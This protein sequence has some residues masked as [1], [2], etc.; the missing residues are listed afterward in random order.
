MFLKSIE[1]IGFKSFANKT[2][3]ELKPGMTAIV[4]PNGCG[5][6]NIS[7]AVRWVLGEQKAKA[8]RGSNMQDV[9]FNGA[10]NAKPMGMAEVSLTLGECSKLLKTDYDEICI[11][12]RV[13][14]SNESGYF[15]NRKACRLKDIQRLFMDTGIGTD[16]YS[17]L[18]QGKIDQILSVRPDDRRSVF[19]EASGITKYKA[20]KKETLRKLDQTENNLIRLDDVIKEVKRQ[21]ISLQRQ[22]GKARRYKELS[23]ELKKLDLF[24]SNKQIIKYEDHL[25]FLDQSL[26]NLKNNIESLKSSIHEEEN[27][28]EHSRNS[29]S[30]VEDDISNNLELLSQTKSQLDQAKQIIIL[31]KDRIN[32][33]NQLSERNNHEANSAQKKLEKHKKDLVELEKTS[34]EIKTSLVNSKKDLDDALNEQK[35]FEQE[36]L[37]NQ[38]N[39]GIMRTQSIESESKT[40]KLQNE[41]ILMD[42]NDREC[43]LRR[44]R[45]NAEK[46]ELKKNICKF[47]ERFNL[48]TN[49]LKSLVNEISIRNKKV[50]K[51]TN[52]KKALDR[53][54]RSRELME[55]LNK[56]MKNEITSDNI[57]NQIEDLFEIKQDEKNQINV[58]IS[59]LEKIKRQHANQ[60]GEIQ[61][62]QSEKN[63]LIKRLDTVSFESN[64]LEK[65]NI[66]K[67]DTR[68]RITEEIQNEKKFQS[69]NQISIKSSNA[70]LLEIEQRRSEVFEYTTEK[71]LKYSENI[72]NANQFNARRDPLISRINELEEIIKERITGIEKYKLRSTKLNEEINNANKKIKP[73]SSSIDSINEKLNIKREER[74]NHLHKVSNAENDL[75]DRRN[76]LQKLIENKSKQDIDKAETVLK[77]D[78]LIKRLSDEYNIIWNNLSEKEITNNLQ[79]NEI[80]NDE[81]IENQIVELKAKLNIIGPV[82]LIAIEEYE[83]YEERYKFLINEK[84]DLINAKKQLLEMIKKINTKTT[85][86]F[87]ETFEKVNKEFQNMFK[88]L[89]GG[90]TAKLV[91]TDEE[92]ILEAG[93]EI[94]A[95]PPGKKLQSI[96][97]LS[98]GERTMTAVALLFSLFKV[99]PSPFCVLD[100]LDAALDDANISRFVKTL[101]TFV[102]GSQFIII[103]HNRQTIAEAS[104]I[105]G[106]TMESK[107]ISKIVSMQFADFEKKSA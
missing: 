50:I 78:S 61:M 34:N 47:D 27:N 102:K 37:S 76:E 52:D 67:T 104:V 90:G 9:I 77:N 42:S 26:K 72:Q 53:E 68:A 39:L 4:G 24:I 43:L 40:S 70:K 83:E 91:L 48:M 64:E 36:I 62:I 35:I 98:G 103:T 92:D 95:S 86:L 11:T 81:D 66:N 99:K 71:R 94:I 15:I 45:L 107:G 101:K 49:D 73:L 7:D 3:I 105:Y 28:A 1:I 10:D 97:L 22:A 84:E 32:E 17:V 23:S 87:I 75:K 33:L 21:I 54:F 65:S 82:N 55:L 25:Y 60:E 44:E 63:S 16:S 56:Y 12:R 8:L 14:R 106:I 80:I 57:I 69:T 79:L 13:Y 96:S 51:L 59:E 2:K 46:K 29:L 38:K 30:V 41:L 85:D 18:E 74:S 89:F 6:S 58:L 5:K 19:E 31:N 20:D 100:E 88:N 93:I